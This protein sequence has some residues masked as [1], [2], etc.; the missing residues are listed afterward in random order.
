[1]KT[2]A[3][4][5]S[6][7]EVSADVYRR[8]FERERTARKHAERLLED[9]SRELFLLNQEIARSANDLE[10]EVQRTKAVF[11]TAAEGIVI[12]D[13]SGIIESLNHAGA[14]IFGFENNEFIGANICDLIPLIGV[15][16][17]EDENVNLADRLNDM[18][19][20][21]NEVMGVRQ[22][23]SNVPLEFVA[24]QFSHLGGVNFSGIIR[25]L[26]R[27]KALERQLAHAQKMESVGQLAAGVAHE[28]N[29]P[30]QFVGDNTQF[31]KTSFEGVAEILDLVQS[32]LVKCR[33]HDL[34]KHDVDE[35]EKECARLD[36]DFIRNEIPLAADQT[37]QGT[38]TLSRIVQAMKVFSH[39][40]TSNFESVD[41]NQALESTL[42]ISKSEWKYCTKVETDFCQNLPYVSCLPGEINQVFLNLI[43]NA[44][45]AMSQKEDSSV[46]DN[47]LTVRTILDD[48][49]VIVEVSDTGTGIPPSIQHRIFDPFFTTKVVGKGTG[50][51]LSICYDIVVKL[52]HGKMTF[53]S[54]PG[55][56]TTFRVRLP[57]TPSVQPNHE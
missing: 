25:D 13:E 16:H 11:E 39:P 28:L 49:H 14:S 21:T 18:T 23:G 53:E 19:S 37:L 26:T 12:F 54:S 10:K 40:G 29:T 50:Q 24:S 52:H 41:L 35:I 33:D 27:R 6:N 55:E 2:E 45:H 47:R 48:A 17:S 31:L 36:L 51:G 38:K 22:D 3:A 42:T 9:H 32:L 4:N 7:T 46:A 15:Q 30:I 44:A 20:E 57:I 56:G 5:S 8:F 1:M 43:V 34:L